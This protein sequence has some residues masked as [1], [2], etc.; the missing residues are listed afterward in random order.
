MNYRTIL[1]DQL[2]RRQ[3]ANPRYSL[4]S[5]AQRLEI[6]PS[7]LSEIL[8]GKKRLSTERAEILAQKLGL[9]GNE[10]DLFVLSAEVESASRDMKRSELELQLK[11]LSE[12]VN[13]QRTTQRNAWYFGAIKGLESHGLSAD[14]MAQRLGISPMQVEN[15][16]RYHRRIKRFYSDRQELTYEPVSV[17]RKIE[18]ESYAQA[19][20]VE[21]DYLW[22]SD[23]QLKELKAKIAKAIKAAKAKGHRGRKP[24]DLRLIYFG[25]LNQLLK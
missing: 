11:A 1:K 23:E 14:E 21:A 16:Q 17:L 19:D 18:E 5:F 2:E 13:A 15:A 7:K 20:A 25:S 4:R 24:E 6:S 9:R 3:T 22:L 10:R 12:Q 8:S